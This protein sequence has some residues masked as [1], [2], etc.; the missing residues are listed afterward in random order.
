MTD[1]TA[2]E[3]WMLQALDLADEGRGLTSPN[4]M[5]GAIIVGRDGS[6]VGAGFHERAGGDHAEVRALAA[7]GEAARGATLYCTLEPCSHRGRTP[8]CVNRIVEAGVGRVVVALRDPNPRVDGRGLAHLRRSGIR[9]DVGI[10]SR[11]A[12]RQNGPFLTWV[13]QGRPFI[14]MKVAISRDGCIAAREGERTELTSDVTRKVVH[15]LR[16]EVDAVG[17]GS[18]TLL[19]DDPLL[20]ARVALRDRPLTRVVFDRRLR[21]P[22]SASLFATLAAGPVVV[23]AAEQALEQHPDRARRL[24]DAGAEIEVVPAGRTMRDGLGHLAQREIT[25]LLLEGGRRLHE[26]AWRGGVVDRV[27]IFVAPKTLGRRAVPWLDRREL[28]CALEQRRMRA[29][30]PDLLIEGNVHRTG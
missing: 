23:L 2:D 28:F 24:A 21:T 1:S 19:V 25:S 13:T 6:I 20:T 22:P 29:C 14:T 27:Q 8:P 11:E 30:G 18:P 4:P 3:I 17:V 9:V 26:A 16:A 12:A 15:A 7:A 5:V 10:C